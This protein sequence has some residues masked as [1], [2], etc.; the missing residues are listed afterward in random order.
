MELLIAAPLADGPDNARE[1]A[2]EG[3]IVFPAE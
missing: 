1:D 3:Y 2:G